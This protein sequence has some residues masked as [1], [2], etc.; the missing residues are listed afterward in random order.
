MEWRRRKK[1]NK[2]NKNERITRRG[3]MRGRYPL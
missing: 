2:K 3:M 1:K